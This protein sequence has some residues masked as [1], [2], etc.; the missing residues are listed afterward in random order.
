M[1]LGK[2]ATGRA[3]MDNSATT[4]LLGQ[5]SEAIEAVK[6]EGQLCIDEWSFNRLKT[7]HTIPG[8]YSEVFIKS[9][10]GSGIGRLF[11]NNFQKLLYSTKP[12][13]VHAVNAYRKQG[14]NISETIRQIMVDRGI[15]DE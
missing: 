6:T 12:E 10:F 8:A 5:K 9:E 13:D 11:V 1:D 14:L 3:I 2:N 15:A 4:L 7:V